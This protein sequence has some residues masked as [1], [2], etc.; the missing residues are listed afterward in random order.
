MVGFALDCFDDTRTS[1]Q[2]PTSGLSFVYKGWHA[3]SLEV[4]AT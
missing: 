3:E 1:T 4:A 2:L